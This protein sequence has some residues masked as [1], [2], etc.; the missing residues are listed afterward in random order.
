MVEDVSYL[1]AEQNMLVA[2]FVAGL[3][4]AIQKIKLIGGDA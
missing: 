4:L 3:D 1:I 2:I